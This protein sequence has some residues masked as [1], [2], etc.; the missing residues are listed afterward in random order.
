M[1]SPLSPPANGRLSAQTARSLRNGARPM[2]S[3]LIILI[4]DDRTWVQ[5][6]VD[7]LR[8]EGFDVETAEDGQCGLDLLDRLCPGLL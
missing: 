2:I 3:H 6:A 1:T 5:A 8:A 7:L 4:D